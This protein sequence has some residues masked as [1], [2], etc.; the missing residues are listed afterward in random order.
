MEFPTTTCHPSLYIHFIF[1]I[2]LH[3]KLYRDF[4]TFKIRF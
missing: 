2:Y 1:A 3:M 4:L